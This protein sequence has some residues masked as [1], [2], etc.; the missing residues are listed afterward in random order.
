V[1]AVL[2]ELE[3]FP[4]AAFNRVISGSLVVSTFL[5][6]LMLGRRGVCVVVLKEASGLN[7]RKGFT[8]L[9]C[10]PLSVLTF[11][12]ADMGREPP[13]AVCKRSALRSFRD[14]GPIVC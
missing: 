4:E 2:D 10:D 3:E 11:G 13:E 6:T 8:G 7:A 12:V 9:F 1:K 14:S 5:Y